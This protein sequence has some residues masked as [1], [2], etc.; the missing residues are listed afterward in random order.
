MDYPLFSSALQS[1][2]GDKIVAR[3]AADVFQYASDR[4]K[5]ENTCTFD[6]LI[7]CLWMT[8]Y[9]ANTSHNK[10]DGKG[11][12]VNNREVSTKNAAC[13]N[14]EVNKSLVV[15]KDK[16]TGQILSSENKTK[17]G[18]PEHI[19]ENGEF[20]LLKSDSAITKDAN[21]ENSATVTK[22]E[23]ADD[24]NNQNDRESIDDNACMDEDA[25]E[26]SMI[27]LQI[28]NVTGGLNEVSDID[29]PEV[30]DENVM[31]TEI[32]TELPGGLIIEINSDNDDN[33]DDGDKDGETGVDLDDDGGEIK[34]VMRSDPTDNDRNIFTQTLDQ[35]S[36]PLMQDSN[37]SVKP[38]MMMSNVH[39]SQNPVTGSYGPDV[40]IATNSTHQP[41]LS[42]MTENITSSLQSIIP[43]NQEQVLHPS[44]HKKFPSI[45]HALNSPSS[46]QDQGWIQPSYF[47]C[48]FIHPTF[49][50]FS[51]DFV[52]SLTKE[53]RSKFV[54]GN[55]IDFNAFESVLM[56]ILQVYPVFH[57]KLNDLVMQLLGN[58]YYYTLYR[59]WREQ[60]RGNEV[61]ISWTVNEGHNVMRMHTGSNNVVIPMGNG[62]VSYF[63][64]PSN[65]SP[66]TGARAKTNPHKK[67]IPSHQKSKT[68]LRVSNK[69]QGTKNIGIVD[70]KHG[71]NLVPRGRGRPRK[72]T[73]IYVTPSKAQSES[74]ADNEMKPSSSKT[75]DQMKY[76]AW[77]DAKNAKTKKKSKKRDPSVPPRKLNPNSL[78]N[79][80]QNRD[81]SAV[82]L[83]AAQKRAQM[84]A[85]SLRRQQK[86]HSIKQAIKHT[87]KKKER[88]RITVTKVKKVPPSGSGIKELANKSSKKPLGY[89]QMIELQRQAA[90]VLNV[91]STERGAKVK[92]QKKLNVYNKMSEKDRETVPS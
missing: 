11:S 58:Q 47:D 13:N 56:Q 73:F 82:E 26:D 80:K 15:E 63:I 38:I 35:S 71:T 85:L 88:K 50:Q 32:E 59:T 64:N 61:P 42:L 41:D 43:Q 92:A 31:K 66:S 78:K 51:T 36:M 81:K 67:V 62:P 19:D 24:E 1:K 79:L 87:N 39:N 2:L 49:S 6:I 5:H 83:I 54:I 34:Q 89:K 91:G 4:A 84:L 7:S 28:T 55:R 16:S 45:S 22:K 10:C 23:S 57:E 74:I 52:I 37:G 60:N 17:S 18:D 25:T 53:A 29:K 33:D 72:N 46:F 30:T 14:Q 69:H 9:G 75:G 12:G 3:L 21:K 40:S 76:K 70:R 77:Q 68:E 27:G 20:T 86:Q 48:Q 65:V 44:Q 8:Y 90:D